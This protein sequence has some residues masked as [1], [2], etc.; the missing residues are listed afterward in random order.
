M[1]RMDGEAPKHA[2]K[3]FNNTKAISMIDAIEDSFPK[4]IRGNRVTPNIPDFNYARTY[5]YLFD[6]PLQ[7]NRDLIPWSATAPDGNFR[8]RQWPQFSS[9]GVKAMTDLAHHRRAAAAVGVHAYDKRSSQLH[10]ESYLTAVNLAPGQAV[11][12]TSPT[13]SLD[14][15]IRKHFYGL[16]TLTPLEVQR[17][18]GRREPRPPNAHRYAVSNHFPFQWNTKD[19]YEYEAAQV[20]QR[21]FFIENE[22]RGV[23]ASEVTYKIV[24]SSLYDRHAKS[25]AD[26]VHRFVQE[27]G[28]QVLEE[29]LKAVRKNMQTLTAHQFPK[30]LRDAFAASGIQYSDSEMVEIAKAELRDLE[31]QCLKCLNLCQSNATDTYEDKKSDLFDPSVTW[32]YLESMEA[33]KRYWEFWSQRAD[34]T[35]AAAEMSTR[36][37]EF[38]RHFRVVCIKMPFYSS[39]FERRLYDMNH[40][41]HFRCTMEFQVIHRKNIVFDGSLF[42]S[43]PDAVSDLAAPHEALAGAERF[44]PLSFALDWT[45]APPQFVA[46]AVARSGDTWTSLASRLGCSEAE[47]KARNDEVAAT[48]NLSLSEGTKIYIPKTATKRLIAFR[49]HE[50]VTAETKTVLQHH[51]EHNPGVSTDA[52]WENVAVALGTTVDEMLAANAPAGKAPPPVIKIPVLATESTVMSEFETHEV[53]LQDDTIDAVAERLGCSVEDIIEVN[54][55]SFPASDVT[56]IEKLTAVLRSLSAIAVPSTAK[57]PRRRHNPLAEI[58]ANPTDSTAVLGQSAVDAQQN[59]LPPKF[60]D[61]PVHAQRFPMVSFNR[62]GGSWKEDTPSAPSITTGPMDWARYTAMYLD[63]QFSLTQSPSPNYNTNPA[64]PAE[65]VPGTPQQTPFEEDQTW[66]FNEQ[67]LQTNDIFHEDKH[68]QDLPEVNHELLAQ[69]LDWQ[70]P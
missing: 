59:Q 49:R 8:F 58:T 18:V 55:D 4:S 25:M 47:L 65:V 14:R 32:P 69:S 31:M 43:E 19:W 40:W 50:T 56:D 48:N 23:S 26:D 42:P 6:Q 57:R 22:N 27:I 36:K 30:E 38:E 7:I 35:F 68:V 41:A 62:R 34:D 2:P 64:W 37:Y 45:E 67:P 15:A 3:Q 52:S 39:H 66:L 5:F 51:A 17:D 12:P 54:K 10:K 33:W 29:K 9:R 53:L 13:V 1:P 24:I 70:A 16:P 20:R 61:K 11:R 63:P 21:R 46:T 44:G 28:Q 60:P